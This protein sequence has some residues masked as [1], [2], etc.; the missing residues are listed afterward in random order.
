M[1]MEHVVYQVF[2]VRAGLICR[3][4]ASIGKFKLAVFDQL[5]DFCVHFRSLTV[6]PHSEVL[7]LHIGEKS[8]RICQKLLNDFIYDQFDSSVLRFLIGPWE[9][10]VNRLDP[11]NIIVSVRYKMNVKGLVCLIWSFFNRLARVKAI[12]FLVSWMEPLLIVH[13]L[14]PL[15]NSLLL[16]FEMFF[17]LAIDA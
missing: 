14:P 15:S 17:G 11:A 2:V 12:G 16:S 13:T 1:A 6:V 10:L 5:L 7:H 9:V 8:L 3:G 4:P